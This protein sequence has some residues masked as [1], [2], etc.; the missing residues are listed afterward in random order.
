MMVLLLENGAKEIDSN[1]FRKPKVN[2]PLP[3]PP[4]RIIIEDKEE[5]SGF[6][7]LDEHS[8]SDNN[9]NNYRKF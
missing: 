9:N 1:L 2:R 3:V 5:K 4:K 7:I 8:I 6:V